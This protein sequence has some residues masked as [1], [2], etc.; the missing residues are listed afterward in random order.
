MRLLFSLT[1]Y[2]PYISGLTLYVKRLAEALVKEDY[3]ASVLTMQYDKKLPFQEE[4]N[5]VKINRAGYIWKISKGFISL[6]WILKSWREVK[7]SDVILISLPQFEGIIPAIFARIFRKKLIIIYH[8]DVV[9]PKSLGNYIVERILSFS[10]FLTLIFAQTIVNNS[11]DF[12]KHSPPLR[13]FW[14]KIQYIYPPILKPKLYKREINLLK[15]KI[16]KDTYKIGFIGRVAADKGI[17]YLFEAIPYIKSRIKSRPSSISQEAGNYELGIKKK[18]DLKTPGRW[19]GNDRD[20]FQVEVPE[21]KIV[22]AGSLDPVGEAKY[23]EKILKLVDKYKN[24]I[25]FLGELKEEEMGSFY[26]L[27]DVL[28]LPSINSTEAFG[29]VQVEAMLMGVPV[30]VTDLPGVRIPIQKTGMGKIV[31]VKNSQKL[32]EAVTKILSNKR[33]Y[34]KDREFI[35]KEFSFRKTIAFYEKILAV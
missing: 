5:G 16:T 34:I 32:A 14:H 13:F 7:R 4:I 9:L 28:V 12:A 27:I 11:Q 29:M 30:I 25:V 1:Y 6:D 20:S 19:R 35:K 23:K 8:C 17:E 15:N 24:Y 10:H 33:K 3:Q 21:F 22:I 26:S 18:R 2:T 31:P